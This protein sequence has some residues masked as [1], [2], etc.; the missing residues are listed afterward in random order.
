MKNMTVSKL[1]K[2]LEDYSDDNVIMCGFEGLTFFK[3]V[4][5]GK[6][7]FVGQIDFDN[8]KR[9]SQQIISGRELPFLS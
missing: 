2:M 4:G 8:E 1:K 9:R 3:P 7:D 6:H 5:D